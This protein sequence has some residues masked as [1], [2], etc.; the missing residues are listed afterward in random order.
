M[1]TIQALLA[2]A[3]VATT[4]ATLKPPPAALQ[5]TTRAERKTTGTE[6]QKGRIRGARSR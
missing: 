4:A 1:G 3:G 2:S 5:Q 6:K